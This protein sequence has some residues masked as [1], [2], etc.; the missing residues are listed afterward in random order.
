MHNNVIRLVISSEHGGFNVPQRFRYLFGRKKR[1]LK[2]HDS[3]DPGAAEL[4]KLFHRTFGGTL[5]ISTISR[6]ICDTNRSPHNP[7]I[8][9]SFTRVLNNE[10]KEHIRKHYYD[11]YRHAIEKSIAQIVRQGNLVLHIAVHTFT[12][13]LHGQYRAVDVGLLYDPRRKNERSLSTAW[14]QIL[15]NQEIPLIVRRNY[16]YRGSTDGLTTFFRKRF[17]GTRYIGIELEINQRYP[18]MKKNSWAVL[19]GALVL[20][21]IE[22]LAQCGYNI[23]TDRQKNI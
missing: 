3:Y 11:S 12:P 14:Q 23:E 17:P 1:L 10:E 7:M 19:Q 22:C 16:P 5:F 4:S 9:S 13:V 8:F 20:S 15:L 21:F 6:L 18:L 2:S